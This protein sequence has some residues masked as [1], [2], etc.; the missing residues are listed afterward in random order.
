MTKH[1]PGPWKVGAWTNHGLM[2]YAKQRLLIGFTQGYPEFTPERT[3]SEAEAEANARLIARAP[4]LLEA[5][6]LIRDTFNRD[7]EQGY[8]SRDRQFA[9]EICDAAIRK[10]E[11]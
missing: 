4:E 11:V 10:V 5:L 9:I 6:K 2:I 1:T 8:R 7:E 3:V